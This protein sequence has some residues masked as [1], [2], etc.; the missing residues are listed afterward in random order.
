MEESTDLRLQP[1]MRPRA[2]QDP[3]PYVVI[4]PGNVKVD[5]QVR[6]FEYIDGVYREIPGGRV[7]IDG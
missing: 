3:P 1:D 4:H 7:V 5:D 2:R 6:V